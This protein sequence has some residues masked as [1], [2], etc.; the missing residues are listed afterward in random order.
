MVN[1][2]FNVGT[3]VQGFDANVFLAPVAPGDTTST[4]AR[5]QNFV[6]SHFNIL[7]PSNMGKW[8]PNENTQNTPTM[9]DVDTILNYAQ[10]HNMNVRMHNLIWGNQQPAWVNSLIQN[11]QLPNPTIAAQAKD[12]LKTAISN[13]IAYYVGDG[14]SDTNDG[15]RA[16]RYSEI[17]VLNETLREG[18]YW[19]IFGPQGIAEIYKKVQDAVVAAGAETRLYTNEYNIFNYANDPNGGASDPYANWYRRHI[20]EINNAGFGE[21]VTGIGIQYNS[22]PRAGVSQAHSAAR[23]NQVLQ[24]MSITGLPISITEFSVPP[25]AGGIDTTEERAALIYNEALRLTYGSPNATSFLLWEPWP[26]ATTDS[27]TIVDGNWNLRQAGQAM[28]DLLNAWKTPTQNLQVGLDGTIDFNGFY[29]DYEITVGGQTFQLSFDKGTP[30]YS[31]VV[32]PGDFNGDGNVDAADYT[33]W[34]DTLGSVNDLR[35]DGNG[36]LVVDGGDY[37]IWKSKFGINYGLGAGNDGAPG[38]A[39]PEPATYVIFLVG[40]LALGR[41]RPKSSCHTFTPPR[42]IS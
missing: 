15:D 17:D 36:D 10:S 16:R 38:I 21:V 19:N 40:M 6:N 39:V 24:N 20:E 13:R 31:L 7:V 27:S 41:R 11:A 35:A 12:D 33:V 28:V 29:G 23:I 37:A 25:T 30:A 5:Y 26:P 22:E 2:A 42:S 4:A 18:T 1:S 34:R 9:N 14:D 8:Q 32:A 3:M